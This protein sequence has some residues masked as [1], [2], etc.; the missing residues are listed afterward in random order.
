MEGAD[1]CEPGYLVAAGCS[2]AIVGALLVLLVQQARTRCWWSAKAGGESGGSSSGAASSTVQNT[3]RSSISRLNR[4]L[5]RQHSTSGSWIVELDGKRGNENY[6]TTT[7]ER[8]D[9]EYVVFLSHFKKE[10]GSHARAMKALVGSILPM[11]EHPCYL[12]SDNL[13]DLTKLFREGVRRSEVLMVLATEGTFSRPWCL[14]EMYCAAKLELPV[15]LVVVDGGGFELERTRKLLAV[16]DD[17]DFRRA[18][19][20]GN[21]GAHEEL[22][23]IVRHFKVIEPTRP[24]KAFRRTIM[25]ALELE[26][27]GGESASP[28]LRFAPNS[29]RNTIQADLMD[30]FSHLA[31]RTGRSPLEWS[32]DGRELAPNFTSTRRTSLTFEDAR[33]TSMSGGGPWRA[34]VSAASLEA[35]NGSALFSTTASGQREHGQREHGQRE[36]GQREHGQRE[37][38]Q[39]EQGQ[40]EQ[41]RE[42]DGGEGVHEGSVGGGEASKGDASAEED[43]AAAEGSFRGDSF[44]RELQA[45]MAGQLPEASALSSPASFR[46]RGRSVGERLG[47][48]LVVG[49]VRQLTR[50]LTS[51]SLP[52]RARSARARSDGQG[53][54]TCTVS[55]GSVTLADPTLRQPIQFFVC[56]EGSTISTQ[57]ALTLQRALAAYRSNLTAVMDGHGGGGGG[58]AAD[59]DGAALTADPSRSSVTLMNACQAVALLLTKDVLR[60]PRCLDQLTIARHAGMP[61]IPVNIEGA[62]YE[63]TEAKRFL[64]KLEDRL[65]PKGLADLRERLAL[66]TP[67][68]VASVG[69][70]LART[71]PAL[72]AVHLRQGGGSISHS[73][74]VAKDVAQR[75][76]SAGAR[77][78]SQS[79]SLG[80]PPRRGSGLTAASHRPSVA[81]SLASTT[82]DGPLSLAERLAERR[83]SWA[84]VGQAS[85]TSMAVL[86]DGIDVQSNAADSPGEQ[87][88]CL[89]ELSEVGTDVNTDVESQIEGLRGG[90]DDL[91]SG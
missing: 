60:C 47:S 21:P 36:H 64:A 46:R 39:R 70:L 6:A 76:H 58:G 79:S 73:K 17:L 56:H 85:V 35:P 32:G 91:G 82:L 26:D 66:H 10:A 33:R 14:A 44:A 87:R 74:A 16:E 3:K 65:E 4:T 13:T 52:A 55:L 61:I 1:L 57:A 15:V 88:G 12:D 50:G 2:G 38:G 89:R 81:N 62:G 90:G 9:K 72:I 30:I 48:S 18:L 40:R 23:R 34:N 54:P 59:A 29:S 19:D 27:D 78:H 7:W 8:R 5:V 83:R 45:R 42:A 51:L 63:F 75:Y 53:V 84:S 25:Q 22:T 24:D 49:R 68:T 67:L 77:R 37:H 80:L 20:E 41:G 28:R 86:D 71:L 31:Q 11:I 69:A 43:G